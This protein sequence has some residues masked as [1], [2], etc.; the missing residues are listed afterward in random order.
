MCN[1]CGERL[2][3][4]RNHMAV[5]VFRNRA[6]EHL[7]GFRHCLSSVARLMA[8]RLHVVRRALDALAAAHDG[9]AQMIDTSTVRFVG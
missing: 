4:Q 3:Y 2:E 7:V 1:I 9:A 6:A 5:V 8:P